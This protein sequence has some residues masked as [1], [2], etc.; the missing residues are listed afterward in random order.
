MLVWILLA[1][2]MLAVIIFAFAWAI[3]VMLMGEHH[4]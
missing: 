2:A 1:I 3:S 4:D